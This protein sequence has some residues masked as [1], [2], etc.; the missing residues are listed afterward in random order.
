MQPSIQSIFTIILLF[1]IVLLRLAKEKF[2]RYD[3]FNL[4]VRK[5][6]F[7]MKS[8]NLQNNKTWKVGL[9]SQEILEKIE[10]LREET[11]SEKL[12]EIM[13]QLVQIIIQVLG[14]N[15]IIVQVF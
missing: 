7:D 9:L 6:R 12:C 1:A 14:D 4:I 11:N 3:F 5:N 10:R 8:K 15:F 13:D 2:N